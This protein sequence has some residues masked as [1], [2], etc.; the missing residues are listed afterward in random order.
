MKKL[1]SVTSVFVIIT[2][3]SATSGKTTILSNENPVRCTCTYKAMKN[4]GRGNCSY[5]FQCYGQSKRQCGSAHQ[6]D[7]FG[8]SCNWERAKVTLQAYCSDCTAFSW[9]QAY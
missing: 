3:M 5:W 6:N 4:D 7:L 2:L 8:A 9:S 1:V